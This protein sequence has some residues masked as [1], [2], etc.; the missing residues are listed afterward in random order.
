MST[1]THTDGDIYEI[2]GTLVNGRRFNPIVL[3]NP[4]HVRH[5][6]IYRGTVWVRPGGTGSRKMLWSVYN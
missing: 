6:N 3:S 1:W 5:Y 4:S 2:T